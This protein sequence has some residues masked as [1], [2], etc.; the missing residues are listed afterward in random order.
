MRYILSKFVGE[1]PAEKPVGMNDIVGIGEY[2]NADR[3]M[4]Y[5]KRHVPDN[6][7]TFN[8]KTA[9]HVGLYEVPRTNEPCR[10]VR[11]IPVKDL[12]R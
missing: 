9:T 4:R 11:S 8:G 6:P 2:M 1:P 5:L 3:A 7:R 12:F 10:L